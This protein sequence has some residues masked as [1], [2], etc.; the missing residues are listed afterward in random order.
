MWLI[1]QCYSRYQCAALC[2]LS[3]TGPAVHHAD[4]Q[5]VTLQNN[6]W[7]LQCYCLWYSKLQH[8]CSEEYDLA[9]FCKSD[10][11]LT[12]RMNDNKI[13]TTINN[14]NNK[15]LGAEK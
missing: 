2:P 3:A 13:I 9:A 10:A 4:V 12:F 8:F 6:C 11:E 14:N 15:E 7:L 5:L 1:V